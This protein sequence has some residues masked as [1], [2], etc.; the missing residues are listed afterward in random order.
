MF[1]IHTIRNFDPVIFTVG[2][3]SEYGGEYD[4]TDSTPS[5]MSLEQ[6]HQSFSGSTKSWEETHHLLWANS[7]RLM[8]ESRELTMDIGEKG[9]RLEEL[10][11]RKKTLEGLRD[12]L[13]AAVGCV[14][15]KMVQTYYATVSRMRV[16]R[17][18]QE[19]LQS[20]QEMP[21]K[22]RRTETTVERLHR[23]LAI[24]LKKLH[25]L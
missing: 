22:N 7:R 19:F 12:Q 13:V 9:R 20:I 17:E 11:G 18:K 25:D 15:R 1:G 21:L 6:F 14:E 10:R 24:K 3:E 23:Q 4:S 16:F 2:D 5:V 8:E